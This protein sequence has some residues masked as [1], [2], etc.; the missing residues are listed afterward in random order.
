[1]YCLSPCFQGGHR[2]EERRNGGCKGQVI[3]TTGQDRTGQDTFFF[4]FFFFFF[5]FFSF[6]EYNFG[7]LLLIG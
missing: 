6:K 4:Y 1:V 3:L 2:G 5:F 7:S